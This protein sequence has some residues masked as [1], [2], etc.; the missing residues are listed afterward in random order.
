MKTNTRRITLTGVFAPSRRFRC[1]LSFRL[2]FM[3]P[4][5]RW[6]SPSPELIGA[7]LFGPRLRGGHGLCQAV[8][9]PFPPPPAASGSWRTF[10]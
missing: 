7:F 3:P 6:T 9:T 10:W 4:F 2:P 5:S 1:T 8:D